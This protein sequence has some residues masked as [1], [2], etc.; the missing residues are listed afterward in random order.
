[1]LSD[2]SNPVWRCTESNEDYSL[3][4][5]YPKY[6]IVSKTLS[7]IEIKAAAKFRKKARLPVAIWQ[8]GAI[9][10]SY[11]T[12]P[13]VWRREGAQYVTLM[14]SAQPKATKSTSAR[15][16]NLDVLVT[17]LLARTT[18][19]ED[20][21]RMC[22]IFDARPFINSV[23]NV[24]L[25]GGYERAN[26]YPFCN[27]HFLDIENIH[28]V[29]E[30]WVCL[31]G[32]FSIAQTKN[33]NYEVTQSYVEGKL[34]NGFKSDWLHHVASVISGARV[35]AESLLSGASAL[36]HCSDGWDR[37]S[38]LT[39]LAQILLDPYFRTIEGFEV[40]I[41][42]EWCSFGHKF[43]S[44]TGQNGFEGSSENY[45]DKD[46]SPIFVQFLD[47]VWQIMS[48]VPAAFEFSKLF[49]CS[50]FAT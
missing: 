50:F 19:V 46:R 38:Q 34:R 1:M 45:L 37:T 49:M 12:L 14:R 25:G 4:D 9:R 18:R 3:C 15:G 13:P 26:A 24:A 23:A 32:L 17:E 48:K 2:P 28:A 40:L 29:R 41:E 22:N 10:N 21:Y 27:V 35:V 5:T 20:G 47:C 36:V 16:G 44:R 43:A 7:D 31:N 30:S 33:M 8:L 11:S 6:L 39:S 42:K